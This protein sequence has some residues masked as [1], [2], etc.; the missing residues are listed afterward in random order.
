MLA[1]LLMLAA[2]RV[3]LA[4]AYELVKV[5]HEHELKK[6]NCQKSCQISSCHIA[7]YF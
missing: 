5:I 6:K 3:S 2:N 1:S 7:S 4:N